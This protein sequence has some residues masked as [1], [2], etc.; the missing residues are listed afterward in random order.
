M[1]SLAIGAIGLYRRYLSP[2]KGFSCARCV[3][4]GGLSCSGF[5]QMAIGEHGLL[6]AVPHIRQR[7]AE[8]REAARE[9][10]ARRT[11]VMEEDNEPNATPSEAPT[12]FTGPDVAQDQNRKDNQNQNVSN[13]ADGGQ[14][15]SSTGS[16]DSSCVP[17]DC[18]SPDCSG[19]DCSV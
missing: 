14:A 1:K 18:G 5:T 13:S 16:C 7:F 9:L 11:L 8:C 19:C 6:G 4:H 12:E 15:S 10:R 2:R 17:T 3:L